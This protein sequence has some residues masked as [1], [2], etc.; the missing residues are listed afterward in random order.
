MSAGK[1]CQLA[2]VELL[3]CWSQEFRKH[4][5]EELDFRKEA[6]T[7]ARVHKNMAK[8]FPEVL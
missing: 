4:F 1:S 6:G 7:L 5:L 2:A 8:A 3:G